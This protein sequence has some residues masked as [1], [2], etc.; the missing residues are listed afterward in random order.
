MQTI[1]RWRAAAAGVLALMASFALEW[2]VNKRTEAA[3]MAL[4][5]FG[6]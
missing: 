2:K 1:G 3:P 6:S 5:Q 4:V